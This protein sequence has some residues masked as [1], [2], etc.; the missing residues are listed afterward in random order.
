MKRLAIAV[1]VVLSAL[2]SSARLPAQVAEAAAACYKEGAL[3]DGCSSCF[4]SIALEVGSPDAVAEA[5]A[6]LIDEHPDETWLRF[7]AAVIAHLQ[8]LEPMEAYSDLADDYE[9][10]R[11]YD[12]AF[13]CLGN[14]VGLLG[15]LG[16]MEEARDVLTRASAIAEISGSSELKARSL[17]REVELDLSEAR[18]VGAAYAR[19]SGHASPEEM[20]ELCP[21]VTR[22]NGSTMLDATT[23]QWSWSLCRYAYSTLTEAAYSLGLYRA[24]RRHVKDQI[25]YL[26]ARDRHYDLA[27]AYLRRAKIMAASWSGDED[28]ASAIEAYREAKRMAVKARYSGVVQEANLE[29]SR[30]LPEPEKSQLLEEVSAAVSNPTAQRDLDIVL[31][32]ETVLTDG[33][34]SRL[35]MDSVVRTAI[36]SG[37]SRELLYNWRDR[38]YVDWMTLPRDEA[39]AVSLAVLDYFDAFRERQGLGDSRAEFFSVWTEALS[40]LTGVLLRRHEESADGRDLARAFEVSERMRA[41]LLQDVLNEREQG[42]LG[43]ASDPP[44][45]DDERMAELRQR[46]LP[47]EALGLEK[48]ARDSTALSLE[49]LEQGVPRGTAV[50]SFQLDSWQDIYG[51]PDGGSWLLVTVRGSTRVYRLP[52]AHQLAPR[53]R[54]F[55]SQFEE[56]PAGWMQSK[57]LA[58]STTS[59]FFGELLEQPLADLPDTIEQLVIVP[60]GILHLFPFAMLGPEGG[61]TLGQRFPLSIVPSVGLWWRWR[62]TTSAGLDSSALV[63]ADPAFLEDAAVAAEVRGE[64]L[65]RLRWAKKDAEAIRK[66][67][68][69]AGRFLHGEEASEGALVAMSEEPFS[70]IHLAAHALV[71]PQPEGDSFILLAP[72]SDGSDGVLRPAEISALDLAGKLIVLATC[73]GSDGRILS[74]EGALSLARPFLEA[75]AAAVVASLW[76]VDDRRAPRLYEAFYRHLAAGATV[77]EALHEAQ[78]ERVRA[79]EAAFYWA[80]TMVIG[81]GDWRLPAT[82]APTRDHRAKVSLVIFLAVLLGLT[83]LVVRSRR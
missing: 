71:N 49:D 9:T 44:A 59:S 17:V 38:L 69:A 18:D 67:L 82:A 79:G 64:P 63:L 33:T 46:L 65:G 3:T 21:A 24:A 74:G 80:A 19:L 4:Y 23:V 22:P 50:L 76:Q 66:H 48:R 28:R 60:D 57:A 70:V 53:I 42:V 8:G 14:L 16:R 20:A 55:L 45:L 72:D 27:R 5:L 77:A 78:G 30:Y 29:L 37:S 15:G 62:Q 54:N 31:A 11:H 52:D 2:G 10:K 83:V 68:G 7:E 1:A 39:L 51:N 61:P 58:E 34:A 73:R 75:G 47:G 32:A 6:V 25:T 56:K 36:R 26:M 13:T 40:W 43:S 41:R 81:N 35:L 12:C